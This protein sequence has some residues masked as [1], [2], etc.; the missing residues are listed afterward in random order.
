MPILDPPQDRRKSSITVFAPSPASLITSF[1][2]EIEYVKSAW[3]KS[4]F[5]VEAD[6]ITATHWRAACVYLSV[7]VGRAKARECV[8]SCRKMMIDLVEKKE[9][10]GAHSDG[11]KASISSSSQRRINT[12]H[13]S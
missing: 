12:E 13:P 3:L 6:G 10:L 9:C 2:R 11:T 7:F 1:V 4:G 5:V 8:S